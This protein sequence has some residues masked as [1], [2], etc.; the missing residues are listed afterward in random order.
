VREELGERA[1]SFGER[2][3]A[4][5]A[6]DTDAERI[7]QWLESE[8]RPSAHGLAVFACG[9]AGVFEAVELSAPVETELVVG[10]GPHLY[11]LARLLDQGR[12]YAVAVTDTHQARIFVV[13]LGVSGSA[14]PSRMRSA[15]ARPPAVGRSALS[16]PHRQVPPRARE[17]AGRDAR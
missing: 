11:P 4:R 17:G 1:R 14:R 3:P 12:R 2:T 15:R 6:Y 5:A 7:V 16:A 10:R 8:P 13:A 9:A